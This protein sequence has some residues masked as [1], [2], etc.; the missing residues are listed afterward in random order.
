MQQYLVAGPASYVKDLFESIGI[1]M[2]LGT[3]FVHVSC[4]Y[5]DNEIN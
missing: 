2:H 4:P 3:D 1:I 5:I